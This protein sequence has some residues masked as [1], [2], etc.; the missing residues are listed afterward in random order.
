MSALIEARRNDGSLIGRCDETCYNSKGK[1]CTCICGG[2]NHGIGK[3]RAMHNNTLQ[4]EQAALTIARA[5]D[6]EARITRFKFSRQLP[7]PLT[8]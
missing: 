8:G 5:T 4:A 7:L 3:I 2:R 1:R 6:L